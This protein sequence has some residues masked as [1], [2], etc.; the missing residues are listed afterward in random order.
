MEPLFLCVVGVCIAVVVGVTAVSGAVVLKRLSDAAVLHADRRG[1]D[2]RRRAVAVKVV[3]M[4][5]S[6]IVFLI[7]VLL[8]FFT[9]SQSVPSPGMLFG[10]QFGLNVVF[11]AAALFFAWLF[12]IFR[13][14]VTPGSTVGSTSAAQ[15]LSRADSN[16]PK[17]KPNPDQ[18][19]VS[20]N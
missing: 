15:R 16:A 2:R 11:V 9:S 6:C 7:S 3:L 1:S 5:A 17:P 20:L 4:G 12:R 8:F 19:D 10:V 14:D 18:S 13:E